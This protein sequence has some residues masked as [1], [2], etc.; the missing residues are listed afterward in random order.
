MIGGVSPSVYNNCFKAGGGCLKF[1]FFVYFGFILS[2]LNEVAAIHP[3]F[4][5]GRVMSSTKS[6]HKL[7][8]LAFSSCFQLHLAWSPYS[9]GPFCSFGLALMLL[10]PCCIAIF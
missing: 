3:G 8:T 5:I 9:F 10:R 7:F 2:C 4:H 1:G 6:I